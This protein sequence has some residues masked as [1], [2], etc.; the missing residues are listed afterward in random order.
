MCGITGVLYKQAR[1]ATESLSLLVK[2]MSDTLAHRG[3][4][5]HGEWV[6]AHSGIALGHRR[7]S[8]QDLTSAGHQPMQSANQ[9]Y[10]IAYNG[11][12]YNFR[13]IR[14]DLENKGINFKGHSDTEVLLECIALYG[15]DQTLDRLNGMFA[16]SLWDKEDCSLT[17][18]RDRVGKKPLYYGCCNDTFLFG[19]ELKAL[20]QHPDF[21][22][23]I[24]RDA[25]AQF[26]QFGWLNGPNTIYRHINKLPAGSYIKVKQS[27]L[28]MSPAPVS[29]WSMS[30]TAKK[31]AENPYQGSYA[32]A[33]DELESLIKKSVTDRM[34]A[35]VEL[36]A[37][38]SG[39]IDSS[40]VVSM[41]QQSADR[42]IKTF[43][44]GFHEA[45]HNEATY[46]KD[47]AEYL[48][49]DHTELY[50][51]PRDC[52]DVIPKLAQIYDEPL[53]DVSQIPTYLVSKLA[54]QQVK[55]VL[56]GDGGDEF[57]A[58]Y[59]RYFRCSRHWQKQKK[60]PSLLRPAS[61][62]V[63]DNASGLLMKLCRNQA[64][65]AEINDWRRI[66]EKLEKR[67]MRINAENSLELFVRM[68][69][70][71]KDMNQLVLGAGMSDT[72]LTRK[73]EWVDFDDSIMGMMLI[74]AC[75][76]LTDDILV[77]VDRASM[78]NSLEARA[79]LLDKNVIEFAWQ[80]PFGMKVDKSGGKRIVKNVLSRYL[81]NSMTERKKMGFG[82]PV[83]T[84]LRGP[85]REWAESLL[86]RQR[87]QQQTYLN[88]IE[89]EKIWKQHQSG[90]RDHSEIL[91]S[92]LMFQGFIENSERS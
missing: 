35:D 64:G 24:D 72:P 45:T 15:L 58:G 22:A 34:I 78:A 83:G 62:Q 7:L 33:T 80:L 5:D 25:L 23:E 10:V 40:L 61:G 42:K 12:I 90:W 60:L 18:C 77:K 30:E 32:Q 76:Y 13:E 88:A 26:I 65:R 38:L 4:D 54:S 46:A 47:I 75:C 11:E 20:K 91:W 66:G 16:I 55:V 44:I 51:T 79:P 92:I 56:T 59:T 70:R 84:W 43:S 50:V 1:L 28:H 73:N 69:H 52:I 89:I 21:D 49:T 29:Y 67:S 9:R 87:I 68:M 2:N 8:I 3:P 6:D 53:G 37:L 31:G 82:V 39:G 74:D 71:H 63:M 19:S 14:R 17:L 81:P 27:N 48:Q 85:L 86:D 57:F 36:G 41:M